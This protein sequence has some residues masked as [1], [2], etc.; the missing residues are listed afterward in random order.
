MHGPGERFAGMRRHCV[1]L[2][3]RSS[4]AQDC[5]RH[6]GDG[7]HGRLYAVD[8]AVRQRDAAFVCK[9]EAALAA[10]EGEDSMLHARHCCCGCRLAAGGQDESPHPLREC[11]EGITRWHQWPVDSNVG[12]GELMA[13]CQRK[14]VVRRG[15]ANDVEFQL[16]VAGEHLK[17]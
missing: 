4:F 3:R 15:R 14:V 8:R 9:I 13:V 2:R 6:P 5:R 1:P 10:D 11:D 16:G 7:Q 17:H 12:E